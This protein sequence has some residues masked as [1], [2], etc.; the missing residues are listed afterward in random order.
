MKGVERKA[1]RDRKAFKD[2]NTQNGARSQ[3]RCNEG[4]GLGEKGGQ[5]CAYFFL[6]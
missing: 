2:S 6:L 3:R 4:I 5:L 1:A